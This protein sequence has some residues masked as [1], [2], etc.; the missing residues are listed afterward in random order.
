MNDFVVPTGQH[1]PLA[2]V[3]DTDHTAWIII[4]TTLGLAISI[5]FG[6]IRILVRCT[7]NQGWGHDDISLAA[8]TVCFNASQYSISWANRQGQLLTF[9]QSA[10]LLSACSYGLGKSVELVSPDMIVKIQEVGHPSKT[11]LRQVY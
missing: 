5:L 1:A 6:A 9:V 10:L 3:T 11:R 7:A 2:V 4:A 8:A